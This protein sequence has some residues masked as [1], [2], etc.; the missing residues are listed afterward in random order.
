MARCDSPYKDRVLTEEQKEDCYYCS[1]C[2][3][4][5]LNDDKAF[6]GADQTAYCCEQCYIDSQ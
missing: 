2:D 4:E 6:I 5:M 3:V 1:H